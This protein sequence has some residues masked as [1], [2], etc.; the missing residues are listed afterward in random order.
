MSRGAKIKDSEGNSKKIKEKT[1]LNKHRPKSKGLNWIWV[2]QLLCSL[3][4]NPVPSQTLNPRV[5]NA[6]HM[7]G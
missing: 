3:Q 6:W 5:E 7:I 1:K 2:I 4:I